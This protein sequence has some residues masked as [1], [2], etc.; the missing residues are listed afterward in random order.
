[1][2]S[3]MSFT[4][5]KIVWGICLVLLVTSFGNN[6]KLSPLSV[7]NNNPCNIKFTPRNE[8]VGSV[9]KMG[10]FERFATPIEGVRA[11]DKVLRA[12]IKATDTVSDFVM[13]FAS[14]D[15][16]SIQDKHLSNYLSHI[17]ARLGYN[18]KIQDKDVADLMQVVVVREGGVEALRYYMRHIG[19]YYANK[20]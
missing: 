9:Y 14:E 10:L 6:D 4:V 13:R 18:S 1:M 8:W 7:R 16:E 3:M 15:H 2:Y 12:N 17:E 20:Q 19:E 11:C 5:R